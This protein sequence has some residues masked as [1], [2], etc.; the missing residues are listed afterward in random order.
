MFYLTN[1]ADVVQCVADLLESSK[2]DS[3]SIMI[4]PAEQSGA[5]SVRTVTDASSADI[6]NLLGR[7]YFGK[8]LT[9]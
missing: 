9:T 5:Y 4:T 3:V 6:E 7:Y 2:T 1:K 8:L